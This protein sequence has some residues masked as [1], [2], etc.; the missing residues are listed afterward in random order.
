MGLG[1]PISLRLISLL[2][3]P[4]NSV[5]SLLAVFGLTPDS[6]RL[7]R[8]SLYAFGVNCDAIGLLS[9]KAI[10][11]SLCLLDSGSV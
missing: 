6:K 5:K 2:Y 1:Y 11:S 9:A 7:P 4:F 10:A 3:T 8:Y